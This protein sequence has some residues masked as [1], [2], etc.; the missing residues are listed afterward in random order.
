VAKRNLLLLLGVI[1][2]GAVPLWLHAPMPEG[3][4]FGGADGQAEGVIAE[5]RPDYEPW[6]SNFWEPPSGE[7]E[8]L[9]FALQAAIGAG[10]VFYSIGYYRGRHV[11]QSEPPRDAS[12]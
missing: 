12:G 5:I 7:V 2:L 10:L 9:L 4:L 3:E 6:Y 11:K 8:S 1:V